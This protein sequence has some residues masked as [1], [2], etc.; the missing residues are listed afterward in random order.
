[1]R[2]ELDISAM[3]D[4]ARVFVGEHDFSAFG[5]RDVQPVRILHRVDIRRDGRTITIEVVGTAFLRGMVRRIVAALLRAGRGDATVEEVAR[6]LGSK[7]PAFSGEAAPAKGLT[8][9]RVP[10]GRKETERQNEQ[11]D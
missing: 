2:D 4:A 3:R 5:G 1:V 8:L 6:A 7:E 10:M 11:Q 9:W